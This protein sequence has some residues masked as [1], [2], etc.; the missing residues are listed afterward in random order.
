MCREVLGSQA[1]AREMAGLTL[2]DFIFLRLETD[3]LDSEVD[4]FI[5]AARKKNRKIVAI[6]FSSMPVGEEGVLRPSPPCPSSLL[7]PS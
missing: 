3:G 6:T 2:T 1:H 7:P 4:Q 5:Q